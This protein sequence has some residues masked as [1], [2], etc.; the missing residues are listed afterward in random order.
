M[1]PSTA[2]ATVIVDEL[3]RCGITD[4]VLCPGSRNAPLAFAL[5]AA[6]AAGRLRLHVRIDERTAG[7][8]ALGLAA[9]SGRPVPV[10]TTSGTAVANLHPA[11]LEASH[12]GIPLLLLTAD[13]PP[14]L[15]G[16]G[17]NQTVVQPGIFADAVRLALHAG[18]A[19]DPA[20]EHGRWRAQV[21]RAVAAARGHRPG[22]V[23]VN[24]P[25]AEPLVPDGGTDVPA[26]RADGGPWTR[27]A[28]TAPL[29]EP[30]PLDPSAPTLVVAGHGAPADVATWGL[31]VVA[32]PMSAAWPGALRTGPW[33]LG[34]AAVTADETPNMR[35]R[36]ARHA[37]SERAT[38]ADETHDIRGLRPRQVIVAG[39]PTL[40]RAVQRLLADP[41][42][43]VHAVAG[44]GPWTDV[45][46]TVRAVGAVPSMTPPPGWCERWRAADDAAAAALDAAL[47]DPAAPGGLRL[48]RALVAA[49]PDGALLTLGSS[50]PVRDVA[51]AAAPR[52]GMTV[53][54]NRGVAGIDGTVSTAA[55]AALAHSGPAYALLGDL[56]LLHDTTGLVIGPG[57]PR[58]DLT[59]VVLND[60]GG[61]I[62]GLLEQ[63]AP[64]HGA[65]FERVFGTPHTVDLAAL[66][67]AVGVTHHACPDLAELPGLVAPGAGVRMVEVRAD[68]A[69]LRA[70]HA[71]V[72]AAVLDAVAS[73]IC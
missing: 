2:H 26:G 64:E 40:H 34:T 65:S 61:G 17:A 32:E 3:V 44:A 15:I 42:V 5:H 71:A 37:R 67:A 16:T 7:F 47:D 54:A 72:R 50:N 19:G 22:P 35:G 55:G 46:A 30:L 45:A 41:A 38:C 51:L 1:N 62:F 6:D 49:L 66:C 68:R 60:G 11:V 53:L 13:R 33:L 14:T 28:P 18:V 25:F 59:L 31:P 57:E 29:T 20:T 63:G 21:C 70:G 43:E 69:T 39:R 9:R 10:C 48:A 8:L 12:A 24:L 52:T 73:A 56:T 4:A 27:V 23:H 58:P 36:I